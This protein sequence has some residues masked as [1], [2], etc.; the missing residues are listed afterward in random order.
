VGSA[1]TDHILKNWG[2]WQDGVPIN[3]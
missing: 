2:V 3:H 1:V